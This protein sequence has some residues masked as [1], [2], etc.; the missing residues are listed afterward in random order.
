MITYKINNCVISFDELLG[1][2]I[3][4]KKNQKEYIFSSLPIFSIKLRKHN[5]SSYII[6]SFD[7]S[8]KKRNRN[9]FIY[10]NSRLIVKLSIYKINSGL[11][12]KISVKNLTS[13][14]IEWVELPSFGL[15]PKLQD[16]ENGEGSVLFPYNEGCLVTNLKRRNNSP[17]PFI[18]PDYPSLGRFSVFPNMICSQFITYQTDEIGFYIGLHDPLRGT[19]HIDF[20]VVDNSLNLKTRIYSNKN[21]KEDYESD[22]PIILKIFDGDIYNG[23]NIYRK[24]FYSH[25]PNNVKKTKENLNDLPKWYN[26]SPIVLVTPLRGHFDTDEMK[27]TK[28]FPYNNA[29]PLL[30]DFKEKIQAPIMYLLMHYESTAPWA[31]PYM[32]PPFGGMDL[33]KSFVHKM[34]E[35]NHYLG[36]YCSGFGYTIQSNL[37]KT[38]N[39]EEEFIKNNYKDI[40]C[41]N[42]DGEISSTICEAQRKGYDLCPS[43][44]KSKELFVNEMNKVINSG[45]DY[46]QALDQNHGGC[47]YFC[48]SDK[49]PHPPVPGKW[50]QIEVNKTLD[51]LMKPRDVLLGTESGASEPFIDKLKFSDNRFNLN[52]YIGMP[53]PLY[54]YI[55][56][57]FLHNFMG[58]QICNTLSKEEYNYTFRLAYS[59]ICGDNLTAVIT[60]EG[61]ISNSW[62]ERITT[63]KEVA[64]TF[65]RNLSRWKL[66]L[67]KD[68]LN[69]GKMIKPIKFKTNYKTF[70]C[71]DNTII[72]VLGAQTGAFKL[73]NKKVQFIVNYQLNPINV[74]FDSKY[75]IFNDPLSKQYLISDNIKIEP[76]N[77]IMIE[78]R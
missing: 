63:N 52:Y 66:H 77:A 69:Y 13:D 64:I 75:K 21:Y 47:S 43:L 24:W 1:S 56:H 9:T 46:V 30:N 34:H 57:E 26:G 28:L 7:L 14:V 35:N 19:K 67:G 62:C 27:P 51:K 15:K 58:N 20:T 39:K 65:L 10:E 11:S 61:E 37:I 72:N 73:K 38:Y 5:N 55:Y 16:E 31:P 74:C 23:L 48:Y 36:L 3:S 2:I 68:F 29:I 42:S 8:F 6:S 60:D 50:Q 78:I 12:F 18:E 54:S 71:E 4:I 53:F 59:F 33:F 41:S 22:F 45:V 70:K 76:L 32:F 49:H 44:E 40:M 25:L 17:F